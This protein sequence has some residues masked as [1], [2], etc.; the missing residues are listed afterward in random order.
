MRRALTL[1][2]VA[3]TAF[4]LTS[5][6]LGRVVPFPEMGDL[7][8]K[9]RFFDARRDDYDTLFFGSSRVNRG[10]MPEVFDAETARRGVPARSFNFGI[11][12][13]EGHETAALVRRVLTM[14]PAR[15]RRVVVE[16]PDAESLGTAIEP[17]NRFKTRMVFWHDPEET[18]AAIAA[19]EMRSIGAAADHLLHGLAHA[20]AAGFGRSGLAAVR[21]RWGAAVGL[22]PAHR[23]RPLDPEELAR[24]GGFEAF[25]DFAYA[26]PDANPM[27]RAFLQAV[28]A[29]RREVEILSAANRTGTETPAGP[30]PASVPAVELPSDACVADW[31]ARVAAAIR[32][33]GAEPVFLVPPTIRPTP[34][35]YRLAAAG[36]VPGF[37]AFNS[38]ADYPRLFAVEN[39][40]DDDHL[41]TEG[42]IH[43]TR[44]LAAR[45]AG[46][47]GGGDRRLLAHRADGSSVPSQS[48]APA[49]SGSR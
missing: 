7:D 25:S 20:G 2:A 30:T 27:R 46:P 48:P 12:A 26:N 1:A 39:R 47:A 19:G 3:C 16:L 37:V 13:M 11:D 29:Y 33:A 23:L 24:T 36:R 38:P 9:L 44:L 5:F 43:F 35:A 34:G 4:G 10:V 14:E 21:D 17:E 32:R 40:F 6:G 28:P 31:V 8:D 15:L 18:A 41:T 42:A 45:L 49:A 22:P